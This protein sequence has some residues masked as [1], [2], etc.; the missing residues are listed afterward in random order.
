MFSNLTLAYKMG[1]VNIW[2]ASRCLGSVV[3]RLSGLGACDPQVASWSPG[4]AVPG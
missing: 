1:W 4:H 3:I 2:R